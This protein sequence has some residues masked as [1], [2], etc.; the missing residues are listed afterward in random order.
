M[1]VSDKQIQ[2]CSG[3]ANME[4]NMKIVF[5]FSF[6][7]IYEMHRNMARTTGGGS[8]NAN[9]MRPTAYVRRKRGGPSN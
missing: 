9:R 3:Y 5:F 1:S 7:A 6:E 4:D 2:K 8:S